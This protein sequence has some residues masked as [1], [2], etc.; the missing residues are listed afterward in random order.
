MR[1]TDDQAER[2]IT[3]EMEMVLASQALALLALAAILLLT[4]PFRTDI[5]STVVLLITAIGPAAVDGTPA[6][7]LSPSTTLMMADSRFARLANN[8]GT[9]TATTGTTPTRRTSMTRA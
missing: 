5:A 9:T 4:L 1:D 2:A 3:F 6:M 8:T 7:T